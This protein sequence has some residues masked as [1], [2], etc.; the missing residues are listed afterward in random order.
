MKEQ[1]S[2]ISSFRRFLLRILLPLVLIAGLAIV[3]FNYVFEQR[4]V[5]QCHAIGAYKINR[6]IKETHPDE[7]PVFGSSRAEGCFIPD[8]LGNNFFNYGISAIKYDVTLFFLD[9]ECRKKKNSRLV[10]MNLDLDGM[11]REVGDVS[12]YLVN[13]NYKPVRELVGSKDQ[14]SFHIPL[15]KY[16]GRY[17]IFFRNYLNDKVELTRFS[18][19]GALLQKNVFPK[20]QFDALV[21]ER[22]NTAT[23]FANDS[24]LEK[25]LFDI[26]NAHPERIFLFVVA[27][28]HS[29]YYERFENKA[30]VDSFF[31]KLR[32]QKNTVVLDFG[33]QPLDDSMFLNT[34][35]INYKG[36]RVFNHILKDTLVKLGLR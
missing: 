31:S 25:K 9:E 30:T 8:S 7:I 5:L 1:N 3:A 18:N 15:V 16:Y 4:I 11:L 34:T 6:I 14:V 24:T 26:I 22:R 19:K 10:I 27:P 2:S 21:Q 23:R 36:A 28:Y 12:N 17:E 35:H 32:A 13:I 20:D 33:K 29:S